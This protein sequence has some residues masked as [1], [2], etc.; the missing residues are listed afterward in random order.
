MYCNFVLIFYTF[1]CRFCHEKEQYLVPCIAI[2]SN[3]TVCVCVCVCTKEPPTESPVWHL[4]QKRRKEEEEEEE[5]ATANEKKNRAHYP[6]ED[7]LQE[8]QADRLFPPHHRCLLLM[9]THRN[10]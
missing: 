10:S 1:F 2:L 5:E 4:W 8:S 3:V 9:A 6:D 7:L